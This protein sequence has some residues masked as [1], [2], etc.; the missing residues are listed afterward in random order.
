MTQPASPATPTRRPSR[1]W[2]RRKKRPKSSPKARAEAA[3]CLRWRH[4]KRSLSATR[5]LSSRSTARWAA[6]PATAASAAPQD[7][8]PPTRAW[9]ATPD[10]VEKCAACH[11]ETVAA[12]ENSLHSNLAGYMTVL[13][14]RSTPDKMPQLEEMMANH[15]DNCHTSC[16]QC[17]VS[18]P[19]NAGG[20]LSAGHEF[21][22]V[23]PMNLTCTGCHGSRIENEYKGKNEGVK[24]D[25]HWIKGGMPC[26]DCH[27]VRRD[28]RQAGRGRPPLRW[29]ADTW[30]PGRRLPPDTWL[31]ATASPT[32]PSCTLKR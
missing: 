24:A 1:P 6:S 5:P 12:D 2:P 27:Y 3:L 17:H 21:K 18:R 19:A 29:R 23:P 13:A 16:G 30:L 25:V 8:E 11:T 22:Q 32:T 14:A 7:K 9:S 31:P 10:S 4:G 20:G 26:F 15:C 28:A